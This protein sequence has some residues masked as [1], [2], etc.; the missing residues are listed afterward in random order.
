MTHRV[1][2][3][4]DRKVGKAPSSMDERGS[5]EPG[6]AVANVPSVGG[7]LAVLCS[8]ERKG[9]GLTL[10]QLCASGQ[11]A[12]CRQSALPAASPRPSRPPSRQHPLHLSPT[13]SALHRPHHHHP[14]AGAPPPPS[15]PRHSPPP[16]SLTTTLPPTPPPYRSP[17]PTTT[18]HN[19][20]HRRHGLNYSPSE[21]RRT[22]SSFK[23]LAACRAYV[24]AGAQSPASPRR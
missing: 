13:P 19:P 24:T 6:G 5:I 16:P 2:W 9:C 17:P 20:L 21:R 14:L 23:M 1:T 3:R 18:R 8:Q 7:S 15:Q 10:G 12:R 22:F 11:M 4:V